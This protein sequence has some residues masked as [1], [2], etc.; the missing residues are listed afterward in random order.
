MSKLCGRTGF[1]PSCSSN[2]CDSFFGTR[3]GTRG[4]RPEEHDLSKLPN[5]EK[6]IEQ[7][8]RNVQTLVSP[9]IK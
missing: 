8:V 9:I 5:L 6:K 1:A 4:D 7:A 2:F 3:D